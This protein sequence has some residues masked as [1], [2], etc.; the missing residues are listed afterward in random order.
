MTGD[1]VTPGCVAVSPV[2]ARSPDRAT[3]SDR[4][5]PSNTGD[6]RSVGV[7][8]SGD[9]D[10]TGGPHVRP[11]R[12]TFLF[13][14][15]L[16][17]AGCSRPRPSATPGRGAALERAADFLIAR[18]SPDGT[19]RSDVYGTFKDGSALTPLAVCALQAAGLDSDRVSRSA[20]QGLQYLADLAQDDSTIKAPDYGFDFP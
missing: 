3:F 17:L 8:R 13:T 16:L 6:L 7:S 12:R 11:S 20:R 19:W 5:S 18:Q 2:V 1:K 9:R 14:S 10:T 4:R 15:A